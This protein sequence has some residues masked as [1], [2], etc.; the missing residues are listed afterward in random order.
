MRKLLIAVSVIA[1]G[2]TASAAGAATTPPAK[3]TIAAS[4]AATPSTKVQ[5]AS[6]ESAHASALKNGAYSEAILSKDTA[7]V[8]KALVA[9][10]APA[11]VVAKIV[12]TRPAGGSPAAR[13][14]ITI[15]VTCCPLTIII[16]I[17]R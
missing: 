7:A 10:G 9:A 5:I 15:R 6:V 12:D 3:P 2:L 17:S 14:R 11:G 16:T 8:Q 13:S 4:M 1:L